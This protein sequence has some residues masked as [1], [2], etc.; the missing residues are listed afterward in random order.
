MTNDQLKET[1]RDNTETELE[2]TES[3]IGTGVIDAEEKTV[4]ML[5]SD[6]HGVVYRNIDEV[7]QKICAYIL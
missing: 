6:R 7:Q 4:V 3:A 5:D 2:F 1:L